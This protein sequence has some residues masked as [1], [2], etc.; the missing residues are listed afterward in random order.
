MR[1]IQAPVEVREAFINVIEVFDEGMRC[2]GIAS[3]IVEKCIDVAKEKGC[4]QIRA[5]CDIN[6]ISSHKLW[7]KNK[8][9]ILP[10]TM[11]DG[12]TIGSYVAHV[13]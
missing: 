3:L 12:R 6:N 10:V 5:Y 11:E 9:A 7:E 8:F 2:K 13:L 1:K 4:Y